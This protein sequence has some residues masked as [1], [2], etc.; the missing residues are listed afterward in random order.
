MF[1]GARRLNSDRLITICVFGAA[2]AL[3]LAT[4][5][6]S[7]ATLFDDSLEFQLITYLP[8]IAHPTGYPLYTLLGWLFTRLPLGDVAYRVNLLS[9]VCAALSVTLMYRVGLACAGGGAHGRVA[10]LTG[11]AALAVSPVFWSQATIAEVYALHA[12]LVASLLWLLLSGEPQPPIGVGR[13]TAVALVFGLGLAHHRTIVLLAPGVLGYLWWAARRAGLSIAGG[14]NWLRAGLA[15]LLPLTLY[16]YLPLRGEVGSLDGSYRNTLAGFLEHVSGAGY[17]SSF[18]LGDPFGVQRDAGFYLTLFGQQFGPIGLLMGLLGMLVLLRRGGPGL[19]TGLGFVACLVFNLVYRVADIE[20]FF[21]PCFVIWTVWIAAGCGRLLVALRG[22]P[23]RPNRTRQL[24]GTVIVAMLVAQAGIIAWHNYPM[25]DRSQ[26]WA[27]HDYG[28][29]IMQQPLEQG[30]AIVGVQGEITLVRYFQISRGL[31]PDLLPV[32]ADRETQ[33]LETVSRLLEEG[34][35]VYL[36]RDLPGAAERWSLGALGPLVRVNA[37]PVF[38]VSNS[39]RP[40]GIQ[41]SP[42]IALHSY[43]LSRVPAHMRPPPVR[44]TLIWQAQA[45][46]TR[47]LKFSVRLLDRH[48]QLVSQADAVP[49]HFTYPTNRWR[50]GELVSDVY[51]LP[52]PPDL[53]EGEYTPLIILYDPAGGA[54]ELSR[55]T[56]PPVLLSGTTP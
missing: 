19:L 18:V 5:A 56:L 40:A 21:I 38:S 11:A 20:V 55:V 14:R 8:G 48:Q 9:A 35:T 28:M 33:R 13:L 16:A 17:G 3:Y 41:L 24:L 26:A 7:V 51:D 34:R 29:D 31:R 15:V 46:L 6:P 42:E 39:L 36:T 52:L 44:L 47:S 27:V 43:S 23:D 10:A 37:Q 54:A 25:M 1:K 12:L 22:E 53:A 2:L 30:A 32:A 45:A 50:P 4:M 49:V